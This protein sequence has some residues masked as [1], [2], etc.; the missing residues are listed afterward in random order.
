MGTSPLEFRS[1]E[2]RR[3]ERNTSYRPL[4]PS[5]VMNEDT[6]DHDKLSS[7]RPFKLFHESNQRLNA[8]S[9]KGI[10]DGRTDSPHRTVSF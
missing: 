9:R 2:R 1:F 8:L 10:V 5:G 6:T 4:T 3:V 7:V